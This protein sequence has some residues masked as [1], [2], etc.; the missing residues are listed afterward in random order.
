MQELRSIEQ[1][2]NDYWKEI[3]YPTSLVERCYS[4]RRVPLSDLTVEQLRLLI[5]QKIG[6]IFTIP[7]A[8]EVLE[9]N[10]LAEGDFYEGDLLSTILDLTDEDLINGKEEQLK[11]KEI[12]T[13][14]FPKIELTGDKT[15]IRKVKAYVW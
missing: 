5:S 4:Y 7:K 11:L 15:L 14:Q 8:L 9:S 10:V 1:L 3:D 12:I 13:A 6:L 2:E